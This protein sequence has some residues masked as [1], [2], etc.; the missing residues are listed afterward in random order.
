MKDVRVL[1]KIKRYM[2]IYQIILVLLACMLTFI[3]TEGNI[4][5]TLIFGVL[6]G[7]I[8]MIVSIVYNSSVNKALIDDKEI[9]KV[10]DDISDE[11]EYNSPMPNIVVDVNGKIIWYNNIS[12][13][14]FNKKDLLNKKIE[15]L[16][17]G[18][19]L[20]LIINGEEKGTIESYQIDS[21]FY[22]IKYEMIRKQ[23]RMTLENNVYYILYFFDITERV[24]AYEKFEH[25]KTLFGYVYIDNYEEIVNSTEEIKRPMMLGVIERKLQTFAKELDGTIKKIEKDRFLLVLTKE[26]LDKV[27]ESKFKILEEIRK[28]N[29]GN[30]LPV[31]LSIGVSLVGESIEHLMDNSKDAAEIAISRGGNQAVIKKDENDY[32]YYGAKSKQEVE[33]NN[34]SKAKARI[35]AY[36]L[37]EMLTAVDNVL[38]MGH[39]NPDLDAI[40][41]SMGMAR[42]CKELGKDTH[43]ILNE[44][45]S[46]IYELHKRVLN[47]EDYESDY[48]INSEEA[49]KYD[50]DTTA[51]IICDVNS[52]TYTECPEIIDIM[53]KIAIIDHHI[54]GTQFVEHAKIV[55]LDPFASSASE[56][57]VQ[58]AQY[59]VE[60]IKFTE[61]EVD[62][63][64]AGILLDTKNFMFKT[65]VKTFEAAAYLKKCGADNLRVKC[66]FQ[67][68]LDSFKKK[69]E[70]I[71]KAEV[72]KDSIII[73][74]CPSKVKTASTLVAQ[75]ADELLNIS[76][77]EASFV[78][79]DTG[80][81]ECIVSARS[82]G[83][84]NVQ[85]IMEDL[86]GG[87]HFVAAGVQL[88]NVKTKEVID[89]IKKCVDTYFEET[90]INT[91]KF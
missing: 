61:L 4:F 53:D 76:G 75:I 41:S 6:T 62:A 38:I 9:K 39:T 11:L 1:G 82:N 40:G 70:A 14:L 58:I 18:F 67:N 12:M 68:D 22:D 45:N 57:V 59:M 5:V 65:G 42:V 46:A 37:K 43:I 54:R 89:E 2:A 31:T 27:I 84:I 15:E 73:T 85:L 69:A 56:A 51:L 50:K 35:K 60:K 17:N 25:E 74:I 71:R 80:N 28:I 78:V 72:Y 32:E 79:Y 83:N 64:L 66:F 44:P 36:A 91:S 52:P 10:R 34:A 90:G 63:M 7:I 55:Y 88:K 20:D 23:N 81:D 24:E 19:E 13:Q 30:E 47:S 29:V 77:I 8:S 86:G 21:N 48:F 33:G 49:L 3:M 87:G 16:I 26:N